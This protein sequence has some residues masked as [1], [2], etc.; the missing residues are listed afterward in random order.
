MSNNHTNKNNQ[1]TPWRTLGAVGS[2]GLTLVACTV[3]GLAAG[4]NLDR[5]LNTGPWLT[6][7]LLSLGIIAGFINIF[8]KT[9]PKRE[10]NVNK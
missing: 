9:M 3:A 7:A 1:L 4:Y 2:I 5:C 10:S 8:Q 6:L